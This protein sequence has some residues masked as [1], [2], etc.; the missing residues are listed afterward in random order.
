VN[1]QQAD[2]RE[3]KEAG[4]REARAAPAQ[5]WARPA[6]E[7][8]EQFDV[9]TQRGLTDDEAQQRLERHGYNRLRA[10]KKASAWRILLDQFLSVIVVILGVAGVVALIFQRWAEGI[11]IIAVILVNTG[12]GFV[13]ELKAVRS[14]EALRELSKQRARVR[15]DGE[16]QEID[17]EHIAPGD[18][19][20]LEA[21]EVVPADLRLVEA[22]GLRVN[23]AALT[24]E[25]VPVDK[26]VDAVEEDAVLAERTG[27]LYK[28]TTVVDGAGVAVAV[29]T[30]MDTELGNISELAEEATSST[31]P[32]QRRL[33]KL[34]RRLAW[35]TL[36]LAAIVLAAGLVAGQETVLMIETAIALGVAAIP[37]GLPIVA[38][39][40]LARGMWLMAKRNAI[41]NR[42][43]AVETLGATSVIFTDKTGTLTENRMVVARLVTASGQRK[44]GASARDA[45][46]EDTEEPSDLDDEEDERVRR[47]VVVS[48]LCN[49]AQLGD[50]KGQR[51]D[52]DDD[53]KSGDKGDPTEVALL[54][55]AQRF[56]RSRDDLE[57]DLPRVREE[58]FSSDVMKMAT[59]HERQDEGDVYVAVKG[60]PAAVLDVCDRQFG[61]DGETD[62]TDEAR[63]Q[64]LEKVDELARQ[65]L[66]LLAMADKSV[67]TDDAEPYE[68]LRFLGLVGLH[69]PPRGDVRDAINECQAAGISVVMVTGDQ[70]ATAE[71]IG[72]EVGIIGDPDDPE[73]AVVHG[74]ELSDLERLD[75]KERRHILES[76]IFSRVS[77]EQKL[78]LVTIFQDDGRTCAMTGD[79]VNDAPALKKAD[80]GVAMGKRGTEAAKQVADMVLRDDAFATIVA[81]VRQ[82]RVIFSNIRK[83]AM[84]MLCTNVAEVMAVAIASFLSWTIPLLPLQILYLNVL[85]D[86]FPALA[87]GV[88]KGSGTEMDDPPRPREESVMTK[89]HWTFIVIFSTI[90]AACVLGGLHSAQYFFD[91]EGTEAVTVSFLIIAFAKLWFVFSLRSRRAGVV[92]NEITRNVWIWA[93]IGLCAALL[94]LAVYLPGL[95]DVLQTHAPTWEGWALILGLSLVPTVVGQI[96]LLFAGQRSK[97]ARGEQGEAQAA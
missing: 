90:I 77:P 37:E 85:T 80:I 62:L 12:I 61:D 88:G 23:E 79:G 72:E 45:T 16:E 40:A 64:W 47:L 35:I 27:M 50:G 81:A 97:D 39:I 32:L 49:D 87:L 8:V 75:D 51:Q 68:K 43:P 86:V 10:Q 69:D 15:R 84:F 28:G 46:E 89:A 73:A 83:S 5:P 57:A 6:D 1:V 94:L 95:T 24:G 42:L 71:A 20:L 38:T 76:N 93:S 92:R 17:A 4:S 19:V 54:K 96:W 29:A 30:G 9:D 22:D 44:L 34:G 18:I 70:P 13:S 14:M 67:D 59:L 33:N 11:A 60:A 31:T 41:I 91:Y 56:G 66:R 36:V 65:G 2:D 3:R 26:T 63:E 7:L 58:S 74:R 48:A 52:D 25:S 53:D 55:M 21:E 78:N 82:G